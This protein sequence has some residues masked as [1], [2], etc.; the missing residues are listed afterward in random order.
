MDTPNPPTV[1]VEL[2]FGPTWL[3]V[4]VLGWAALWLIGQFTYW[5]RVSHC[6]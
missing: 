2:Q 4:V 6:G 3:L 1:K 5:S